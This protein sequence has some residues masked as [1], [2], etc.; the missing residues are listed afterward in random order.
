MV[1]IND[2][3]GKRG[4]DKQRSGKRCS[5]GYSNKS[6]LRRKKSNEHQS[7]IAGRDRHGL[8]GDKIIAKRSFGMVETLKSPTKFQKN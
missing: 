2:N 5:A 8:D 7:G 6:N 3:L 4:L 1:G